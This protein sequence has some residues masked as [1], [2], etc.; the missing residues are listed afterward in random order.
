MTLRE[1]FE[2]SLPL[3]DEETAVKVA[4]IPVLFAWY[5]RE[6]DELLRRLLRQLLLAHLEWVEDALPERRDWCNR[7]RR[8][9]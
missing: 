8:W 5:Q 4:R 3:E 9:L 2:V 6:P 1:L 7:I